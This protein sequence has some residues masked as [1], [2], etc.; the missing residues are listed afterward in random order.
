MGVGLN[1]GRGFVLW[2]TGLSGA[3]KTTLA[4]RLVPELRA[5]GLRV[6]VLDG[7]EVRTNLSKGLGFSKEDRD[8]NVRRIGYVARLLARNGVAAVTAAISPYAEVRA[9]VR[10]AV[11]ADGAE[12]VEVYVECPLDVLAER[13][14]KG[15]YKKALA[16]E[17]QGFTGVSDPYEEPRAPDVTVRTHEEAVEASAGRIIEELERRGLLGARFDVE[18]LVLQGGADGHEHRTDF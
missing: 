10:R 8:T 1:E 14:V 17:I 13:D 5:R 9:E 3:G 7:D 2:L 12:F 15:L 18:E 16:G 4:G 11:E 6:E